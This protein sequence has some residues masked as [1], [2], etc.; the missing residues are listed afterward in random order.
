MVLEYEDGSVQRVVSDGTWK[1]TTGGPIRFN[2][3]RA[4]ETYDARMELGRLEQPGLQDGIMERRPGCRGADRQ[5]VNQNL[6][7][8]R[9]IAEIPA[10]SVV[11]T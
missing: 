1:F 5:L 7:P 3:V 11:K 2:S 10:V 4:G 9:R 6:P 8:V